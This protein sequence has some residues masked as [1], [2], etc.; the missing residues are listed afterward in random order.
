MRIKRY[1]II[2]FSLVMICGI[3]GCS[4]KNL[5]SNDEYIFLPKTE[6]HTLQDTSGFHRD[7]KYTYEYDSYGNITKKEDYSKGMFYVREARFDTTYTYDEN[8]K[9]L[10]ELIREEQFSTWITDGNGVYEEGY[11]YIY[12]ESGQLIKKDYIYISVAEDEFCGYKY[13]YDEHGNCIKE[14]KYFSDGAEEINFEQ[15]Y[16]SNN[17]LIKK[18]YMSHLKEFNLHYIS[19]ETDYSYDDNGKLIYSKKSFNEP[20]GEISHYIEYKYYYDELN[21]LIK[22][23]SALFEKDGEKSREEIREYKDFIKVV[24]NK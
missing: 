8:G 11:N 3:L 12:N 19:E 21:R 1:F 6:L 23:E 14:I 2:A 18:S 9:I 22:E 13:E 16:D 15:I 10:K 5:S 20:S 4:D 24:L 7:Y 17:K